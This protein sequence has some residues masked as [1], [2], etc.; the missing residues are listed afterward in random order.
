MLITN[1]VITI[2]FIRIFTGIVTIHIM[3]DGIAGMETDGTEMVGVTAMDGMEITGTEIIGMETVTARH[4][5][6]LHGIIEIITS[7]I[8]EV[9]LKEL[10][11]EAEEME[12]LNLKGRILFE[13]ALFRMNAGQLQN[14][15]GT[16]FPKGEETPISNRDKRFLRDQNGLQGPNRE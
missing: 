2:H 11:T 16:M 3:E 4:T 5:L 13:V 9:I 7:I 12:Q 6:A 14:L 15:Q 8:M 10:I 1:L